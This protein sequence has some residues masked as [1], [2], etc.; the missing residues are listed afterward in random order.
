MRRFSLIFLACVVSLAACN[1]ANKPSDSNFRKAIN[2]YLAKHG[3]AC[4][5]MGR[6]FPIDV[7]E[8]EQRLQFGTSA[9]M[10]TLEAA[11]LVLPQTL[12]LLHLPSSARVRLGA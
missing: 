11:G 1:D 10:A 9:E 6:P 5:W 8:P 2:Q 3:K 12:S 7:S 4:T